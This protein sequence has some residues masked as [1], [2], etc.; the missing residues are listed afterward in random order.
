M[1]AEPHTQEKDTEV[2]KAVAQELA[3]AGKHRRVAVRRL[4]ER[5]GRARLTA[6]GRAQITEALTQAGV[7][8]EPDLE[9]ASLDEDVLLRLTEPG[10]GRGRGGLLRSGVQAWKVLV[11]LLSLL[12]TLAGLYTFVK[13]LRKDSPAQRL[14][15]DM[16]IA[17]APFTATAG[18]G[19]V[20]A[21][22]AGEVLARQVRSTLGAQ[23]KR[24]ADSAQVTFDVAPPPALQPLEGRTPGARTAAAEHLAREVNA[25]IVVYGSIR[26]VENESIIAPRFYLSGQS[27]GDADEL[28]GSHRL[29]APAV[30]AGAVSDDVAARLEARR[31]LAAR[32]RVLSHFVI[33]LSYFARDDYEEA[34]RWLRQARVGSAAAG[35]QTSGVIDLFLGA[36]REELGRARSCPAVLPKGA[37]RGARVRTSP[38]RDR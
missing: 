38:V 13:E 2:A 27:L 33:G 35:G 17:V 28:I 36:R 20:E 7:S 1:A 26:L 25:Q 11:A 6:S 37:R 12:A 5:F 34:S 32:T 22:H 29:G 8:L 14:A 24:G 31:V 15:G 30:V 23:L 10:A 21:A 16:N 18:R 9:H 19:E 3:E 4:R